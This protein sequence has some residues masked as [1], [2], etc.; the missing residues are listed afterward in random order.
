MSKHNYNVFSAQYPS[1]IAFA[2]AMLVGV[3]LGILYNE[4][5]AFS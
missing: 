1:G 5:E 4:I 3:G 2:G